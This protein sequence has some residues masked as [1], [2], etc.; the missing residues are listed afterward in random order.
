MPEL[1]D[2][3]EDEDTMQKPNSENYLQMHYLN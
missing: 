1:D 2:E 3:D